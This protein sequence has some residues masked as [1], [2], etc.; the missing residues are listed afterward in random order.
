[1]SRQNDLE[2]EVLFD[3]PR[4][5]VFRN[6]TD[7]DRIRTWFAPD[8]FEV[9]SCSVEA[10]SGGE[11]QV[12]YRAAHG[13]ECTEYGEFRTVDEPERLI[14][15]L[16]QIEGGRTVLVSLV[17]VTFTS[18][19]SGTRMNFHQTGFDTPGQHDDFQRGWGEC[20][21]KLAGSLERSKPG[22]SHA[23]TP[24]AD[25]IGTVESEIRALLEAWAAAVRRHDMPAILAFH[26]RDIVMFDLPPPLQARGLDEYKKTWDLFFQYHKVSQ[27]FDIEEL[28]VVA[29]D[30]VGFAFGL[31]RCGASP[32]P[33][34]F[35]FRVTIGL[36]Q[37][38]GEW[39]VVHEHHSLPAVNG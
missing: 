30:G 12:T 20:F 29:S 18:V 17:T 27:A 37:S 23:E 7:P 1:V 5:E 31:M 32:D 3:A 10:H 33:G 15:T 13:A 16:T 39:R 38:E 2:I 19:G 25:A 8:G 14:F 36:R 9:T 28:S 26:T 24:K 34:G 4:E 6:W 11:W 22:A 21:R 35:L